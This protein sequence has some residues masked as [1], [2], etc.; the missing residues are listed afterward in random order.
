MSNLQYLQQ[1]IMTP[2]QAAHT[3]LGWKL[4][5]AR[6]GFTNGCFDLLHAGHLHTLI[7]TANHSDKLVVGLNSDVSV[8]RLKGAGRPLVG[9]EQRALLLAAF[10]FVDAVVI[11]DQDTPLELIGL[12]LPD[13]LVKGGD[14]AEKDIV[15]A[16]LVRQHGGDVQV[17]P[18]LT[19]W[20]TTN[21]ARKLEQL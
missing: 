5:S 8:S 17:V 7:H 13:L 1:K 18:Y 16:D 10:L 20:S 9:Q 3:V 14:W 21:L 4:K 19:G 15:G 12:L 6:I 2:D 11:F